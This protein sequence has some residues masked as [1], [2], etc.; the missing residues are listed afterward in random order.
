MTQAQKHIE[1]KQ[2]GPA[3]TLIELLVVVA[4]VSVLAAMISS[5]LAG[6]KPKAKRTLCMNNLRQFALADLGYANDHHQLPS[7]HP[8]IPSSISVERLSQIATE[9]RLPIPE[10]PV[11][12]WPKRALQPKWINC[13]MAAESGLAEGIALGGGLYTGYAYFGGIEVSPMVTN[14]FASLVHS[15]QAA[16]PLNTRRGVLWTDVLAE[17]AMDDPRRFEFFHTTRRVQYPDFRFH[18]GQLD[19]IHRAWSDGSVE[20]VSGRNLKLTGTG[21]SDCRIQHL[22]GNYYY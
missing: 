3:F 20:W 15:G 8:F 2:R 1:P 7:P 4:I 16:D 14:G 17:F 10:G 9:L 22:L 19:G 5:A 12:H 13:P 6:A 21:S 18:A 11:G